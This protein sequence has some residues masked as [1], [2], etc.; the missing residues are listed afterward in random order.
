MQTTRN[1]HSVH[2]ERKSNKH[3]YD[4][5]N[6]NST[7]NPTDSNPTDD[8]TSSDNLQDE[9]SLH[10][11]FGKVSSQTTLVDTDSSNAGADPRL[12]VYGN[13]RILGADFESQRD[14]V[15]SFMHIFFLFKY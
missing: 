12:H 5:F 15:C 6:V 10:F 13:D 2:E 11:V 4:N 3:K 9:K 1:P 14:N 7:N 8:I